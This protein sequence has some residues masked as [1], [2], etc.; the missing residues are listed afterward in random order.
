MS[1]MARATWL[2]RMTGK[3]PDTA[4]NRTRARRSVD[5]LGLEHHPVAFDV[6][7]PDVEAGRV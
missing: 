7:S 3:R 5:P 6:P 2:P 1:P 4:L